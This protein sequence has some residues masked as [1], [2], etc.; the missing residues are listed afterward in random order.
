MSASRANTPP[1]GST[2]EATSHN[3]NNSGETNHNHNL[4]LKS[5]QNGDGSS[6]NEK[7]S[8]DQDIYINQADGLP[9]QHPT[10]PD[11]DV[12]SE[13]EK[14]AV[15]PDSFDDLPTSII[16]TNIHSE[17]FTNPELKQ[18]ME[19]LFRTFCDSATFQW[20]RSFRRLRVN[21]DNAIAAA[22]A[23]IK[24][25]QYEF[26]KKTTITCY[27]AQPVTPVSNKNLQPP[28]PV[29]Q[30]LISPPASPPAGWEPREENEPLVN[31]DLLAALASLTP[32]ESHELHP[33]S[34]D[35][36]G[37]IVHTAML[38]EG[39]VSAPTLAVG[40]KPAIVQTKCP[41]RA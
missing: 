23:R 21:Y 8:P 30:F 7:L 25:H 40:A 26:N 41:E 3:H 9:S 12:D 27:F 10:L 38:P 20:L 15:D 22:N 29:K 16:V 19:E 11:G 18:Q 2:D 24:L 14:E 6:S 17:V 34:E 1:S 4:K 31:H 13:S 28:A 37:I 33:Q 39:A 36:P 32:G 35:Q 5:T